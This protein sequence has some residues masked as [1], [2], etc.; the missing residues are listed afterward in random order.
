MLSVKILSLLVVFFSINSFAY[1][2]NNK[3]L[4]F[5]NKK[6]LF[7]NQRIN[8]SDRTQYYGLNVKEVI[9]GNVL[10]LSS[11]QV[12]RLLGVDVPS[13]QQ[14]GKFYNESK[15]LKIPIEV[16][17]VMAKEAL[18]FT[19]KLVEKKKI[20]IEF[21][22]QHYDLYGVLIGYVYL[23]EKDDADDGIFVNAEI[24]KNG[25]SHY[26][27]TAPNVRY[28]ELFKQL[29]QQAKEKARGLWKQWQR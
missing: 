24:I 3:N 13:V 11:G 27:D 21:D 1:A 19:K 2:R 29:H 22:T 6:D 5:Y 4:N 25:Y 8:F 28:I 17:S 9:D 10:R 12:F 23:D 15:D 16:L 20:N 7:T 26:V 14:S 18:L